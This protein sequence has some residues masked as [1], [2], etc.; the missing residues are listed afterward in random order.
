MFAKY[1]TDGHGQGSVKKFE[2]MGTDSVLKIFA[3]MDTECGVST[4]SIP[5]KY[6][7]IFYH[8]IFVYC[9]QMV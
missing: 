6:G 2:G 5:L 3:D 7:Y 8:L 9:A 1:F 4:D